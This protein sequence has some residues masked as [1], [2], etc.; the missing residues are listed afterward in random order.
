[1]MR[2][3]FPD[4]YDC[5]LNTNSSI[6]F[7]EHIEVEVVLLHSIQD[8]KNKAI[9]LPLNEVPPIESTACF[10]GHRPQYFGTFDEGDALILRIKEALRSAVLDVVRKKEIKH[11]IAGGALGVD[12]WAAEAVLSVQEEY[13]DIKLYI[14]R[15]FD[16]QEKIWP[17][18]DQIRYWT[19]SARSNGVYT[20]SSG[21]YSP[22]AMIKR[23][24]WLVDHSS[25]LIAVYDGR[26]GGGTYRTYRYAKSKGKEIIHIDP[27]IFKTTLSTRHQHA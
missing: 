23:N 18:K 12:T 27:R 5:N 6:I 15:P 25:V 11:F 21:S 14:A 10:S 9:Y 19:I 1:M 16:Q 3:Y 7:F 22:S 8:L 13:P 24:E 4:P 26:K 20:I 17:L 2:S